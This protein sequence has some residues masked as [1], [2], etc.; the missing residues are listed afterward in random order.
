MIIVLKKVY[1][2]VLQMT[3]SWGGRCK[4]NTVG[5]LKKYFYVVLSFIRN[6]L[7]VISLMTLLVLSFTVSYS[8]TSM[9]NTNSQVHRIEQ[10]ETLYQIV[11]E[12]ETSVEDLVK[13]NP[14]HDLDHIEPGQVLIVPGDLTDE[15]IVENGDTMTKISQELD[16]DID[17]LA[18]FNELDD[19][20][21]I[22][23]GQSFKYP[24]EHR[25]RENGSQGGYNYTD[26]YENLFYRDI[27]NTGRENK[28]IALTFDDGPDD[29]YTD[30]VIDI[31]DN[32]QI[33]A[34]FYFIGEKVTEYPEVVIRAY[35]EGHEIG[36]HSWSHANFRD[37]D[38]D[39]LLDELS[40]TEE[41]IYQLTGEL[42]AQFRPPYGAID[43]EDLPILYEQ[44][45]DVVN[46][47]VDTRDWLDKHPDLFHLNTIPYVDDGDIVLMHSASGGD[48]GSRKHML[49]ALP[50]MI[51]TLQSQGYKFVTVSE[52]IDENPYQ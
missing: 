26:N 48:S 51:H 13:Q 40:K 46:W 5:T 12:Y 19:V 50:E 9:A 49:T 41:E 2:T 31:L 24:V 17:E 23:P 8:D 11:Q 32:Y 14:I 20:D 18:E 33:P 21:L 10:G 3:R 52:L 7:V 15:Y 27:D 16:L 37:L 22:H 35:K 34:N 28:K 29:Y 38:E 42:T 4:M 43:Y 6:R 30:E 25:S 1:I 45:Y 39:E 36:N 44:G 47:S